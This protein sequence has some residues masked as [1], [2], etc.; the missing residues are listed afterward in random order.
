M[1]DTAAPE[2]LDLGTSLEDKGSAASTGGSGHPAA[3]H[4]AAAQSKAAEADH[5][6]VSETPVPGR[7]AAEVVVKQWVGLCCL[8]GGH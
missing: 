6:E 4:A 7:P 8:Q 2:Q 3:A 1:A 5:N